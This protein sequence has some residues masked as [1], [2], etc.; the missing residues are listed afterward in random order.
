[1]VLDRVPM[2]N[3]TFSILVKLYAHAGRLDQAM[4][5]VQRMEPEFHVKPT[6]VVFYVCSNSKLEQMFYN[7]Y[8]F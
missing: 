6:N 3:I 1:M 7:F 5:L 4:S 8:F 2:S